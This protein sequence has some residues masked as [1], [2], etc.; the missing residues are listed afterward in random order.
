MKKNFNMSKVID[1]CLMVQENENLA[2]YKNG[3]WHCDENAPEEVKEFVAFKNY[4]EKEDEI[5]D[6]FIEEAENET[7]A[8]KL[9]GF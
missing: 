1:G 5:V 6:K 2:I 4:R 3:V 7:Q 8:R 9:M